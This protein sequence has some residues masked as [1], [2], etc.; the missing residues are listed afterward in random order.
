MDQNCTESEDVPFPRE[1][2]D[3]ILRRGCEDFCG[4]PGSVDAC[5]SDQ[6]LGI[7]R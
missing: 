7:T 6:L 2:D 5:L 3:K 4:A 1:R